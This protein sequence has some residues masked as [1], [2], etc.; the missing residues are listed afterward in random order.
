MWLCATCHLGWVLLG[1]MQG[2]RAGRAALPHMPTDGTQL[3]RRAGAPLGSYFHPSVYFPCRAGRAR[4]L[5]LQECPVCIPRGVAG[6]ARLTL[7]VDVC[8]HTHRHTHRGMAWHEHPLHPM[9]QFEPSLNP[10][11]AAGGQS[12]GS[13]LSGVGDTLLVALG[14]IEMGRM[15]PALGGTRLFSCA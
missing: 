12:W 8:T 3:Q 10:F 15:W 6:P 5:E 11:A 2:Q 13:R 1:L 14:A 4:A 9:I 7:C